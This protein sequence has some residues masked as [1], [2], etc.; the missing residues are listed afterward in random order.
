MKK[1]RRLK[2]LSYCTFND[3][4]Q[5]LALKYRDAYVAKSVGIRVKSYLLLYT[6][7]SIVS[8]NSVLSFE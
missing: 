8:F 1:N 6:V 3:F 2:I 7:L 5:N 4:L